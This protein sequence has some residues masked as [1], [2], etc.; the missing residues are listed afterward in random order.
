MEAKLGL[1]DLAKSVIDRSENLQP[2]QLKKSKPLRNPDVCQEIEEDGSLLLLA[3]LVQQGRGVAGMLAKWMKTPD[4]KK[5][6]LEP[7]GA[8]VWNLCDGRHTFEGISR[9]LRE[10][11][12]MNRLEADA[13][14]LA[15]LQ[16]L[17]QRR[18][19]TLTVAKGK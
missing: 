14:L 11:F 10:E 2:D 12:K 5:F 18:L 7:V 16:M 19:I 15:F 4:V 8:F 3:P 13:S 1:V 9:A 17:S 6:E